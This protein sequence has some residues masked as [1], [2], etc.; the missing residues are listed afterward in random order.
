MTSKSVQ[1]TAIYYRWSTYLESEEAFVLLMDQQD[2]ETANDSAGEEDEQYDAPPLSNPYILPAQQQH[3]P[4]RGHE[5]RHQDHR[6]DRGVAGGEILDQ[7]Q[8]LVLLPEFADVVMA[9]GCLQDSLLVGGITGST[10]ILRFLVLLPVLLRAQLELQLVGWA[11]M[12]DENTG[13]D[14]G[15]AEE[16]ADGEELDQCLYVD[17]ES[18]QSGHEAERYN[19]SDWGLGFGMN[20]R[21]KP[22]Q[23][24]VGGHGI[25]GTWQREQAAYKGSGDA[26]HGA[27]GNEESRPMHAALFKRGRKRRGDV[28]VKVRDHQRQGR[29]AADVQRGDN[30]HGKSGCY[31]D[32][33]GRVLSFLPGH[34]NAFK[35]DI[36]VE[37][38]R[39]PGKDAW[40]SERQETSLLHVRP[41][42]AFSQR[43]SHGDYKQDDEHVDPRENAVEVS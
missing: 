7:R 32:R 22:E 31:G 14:H 20:D 30:H 17:K 6:S 34:S 27:Y 29:G 3:H 38:G 23:Q 13:G 43:K 4:E 9:L 41:V 37:A 35:A 25:R 18:Q 2:K 28:D 40:A 42:L 33:L 39:R 26:E 24:T 10:G 36:S 15:K 21:E 16:S 8:L 12:K 11:I 1:A 5:D 19:S